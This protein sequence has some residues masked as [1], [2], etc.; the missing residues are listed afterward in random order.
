MYATDKMDSCS[1]AR[2]LRSAGITKNFLNHL[3]FFGKM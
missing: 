2:L 1:S 3:F